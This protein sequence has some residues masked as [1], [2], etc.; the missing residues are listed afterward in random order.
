[1]KEHAHYETTDP[2]IEGTTRADDIRAIASKNENFDVVIAHHVL[3]HIDDDRKAL[4]EIWRVLVPGGQAILSAPINWSRSGT[5]ESDKF[6]TRAARAAAYGGADHVR[7]Y[8]RDF[9]E[10]IRAAGF[11]VREF[12]A[13]PEQ[14]VMLGLGRDEA[15][16]VATKTS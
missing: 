14:E 13:E 2:K 8:G 12:R 9:P 5:F 6:N 7:Y 10:R 4:A 11:T 1:M 15:I 3:E 16:Y